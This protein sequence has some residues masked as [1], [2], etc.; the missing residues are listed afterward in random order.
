MAIGFEEVWW[1][2]AD[3]G[4]AFHHYT[5]PQGS[6]PYEWCS[7]TDNCPSN[8]L[9]DF[10]TYKCNINSLGKNS[11]LVVSILVRDM[12]VARLWVSI[13]GV[14]GCIHGKISGVG[15]DAL[16]TVS[17]WV[18]VLVLWWYSIVV[19]WV[20][21]LIISTPPVLSIGLL[22]IQYGTPGTRWHHPIW[23]TMIWHITYRLLGQKQ[24]TC[25]GHEE[26]LRNYHEVRAMKEALL[27]LMCMPGCAFWYICHKN[28]AS[29]CRFDDIVTPLPYPI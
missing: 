21:V 9:F 2:T 28:C 7:N 4:W 29:E 18:P 17:I 20:I 27:A 26:G 24:G 5:S 23:Q 25:W 1:L 12:H 3:S 10:L 13:R 6:H 22:L 14:L 11:K 8:I 19:G 16:F 15:F